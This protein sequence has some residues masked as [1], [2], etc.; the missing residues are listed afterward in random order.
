MIE[1]E[2]PKDIRKYDAKLIGP[3]TTRQVLCF[4]PGCALGACT[5]LIPTFLP[6][7]IRL[8][9]TGIVF[10]PFLLVGWVKPYGMKF[11]LFAK[12]I[13]FSTFLSP[14]ERKYITKNQFS[15]KTPEGDKLKAKNREKKLKNRKKSND[16][17]AYD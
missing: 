3:F 6:Q 1:I 7:D 17:I 14:Q 15:D 9:L 2:I 11:E 5:F 16:F 13:I 8:I 4:I 12:Q 10:L